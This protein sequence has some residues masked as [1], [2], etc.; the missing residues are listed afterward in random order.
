MGNSLQVYVPN[1]CLMTQKYNF[2][3]LIVS[4]LYIKLLW[5]N[6]ALKDTK[7]LANILEYKT[8]LSLIL[9][10]LTKPRIT[11]IE[12]IFQYEDLNVFMVSNHIKDPKHHNDLKT[13]KLILMLSKEEL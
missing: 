8:I 13:L 11:K 7:I 3:V 1:P 4:C 12:F 5:K 9:F 6:K 2:K 10:I